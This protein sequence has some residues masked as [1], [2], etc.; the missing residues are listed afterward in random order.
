MI[1]EAVLKVLTDAGIGSRRRMADAIRQARVKL[2]GEVVEDFRH[3]VNREIDRLYID[4]K[5]VD[6][7]LKKVVY[8]MLNKPAGTLS[9]ASDERR[10]RTVM[11]SLPEK[12]RRLRLYPVGR[13]DKDSTG[14]LL[15]TNDGEFTYQLTHPRFEHEKEYLIQ[16][17]GNL[18]PDGERKLR[19]G[20]EL[21]DG[22]TSPA[23]VR[24]VESCPP[25]N[26]SIIIHEGRKRQVHR[27]L[28]ALGHR[29]L[30][31]KRIRIG[32]LRLGELKE[33]DIRELSAGE[34]EMLSGDKPYNQSN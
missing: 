11:H 20:I 22:R 2:N 3:P 14:L 25:F 8:L 32:G 26:Y 5:L 30:A 17:D 21:E 23:R 29:V 7:G 12:Y 18:Q 28:A 6:L 34:I 13:L 9:T 33:G 19:E 10:R 27:M 24:R 31:L 16:V 4:G 15:L 1:S